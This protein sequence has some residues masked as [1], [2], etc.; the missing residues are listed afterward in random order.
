MAMTNN[1]VAGVLQSK[2]DR[3]HAAAVGAAR[4]KYCVL[5]SKAG[6]MLVGAVGTSRTKYC[7]LQSRE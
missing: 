4:T 6:N 1:F 3:I 2:A 5:Q 7:V